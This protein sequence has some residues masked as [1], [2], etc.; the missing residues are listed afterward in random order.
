M[1]KYRADVQG[2]RENVWS[3]N[4]L[5]FDTAAAAE[6]YV[7]ELGSRWFGIEAYRVVPVDTPR[8]ET[9]KPEDRKR[10]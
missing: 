6:A 10:F 9:V 2:V 7:K 8:G 3:T 4:G 1:T 5:E